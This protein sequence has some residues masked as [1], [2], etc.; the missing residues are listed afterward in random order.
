MGTRS[1]EARAKLVALINFDELLAYATARGIKRDDLPGCAPSFERRLALAG[2]YNFRDA[3][4]YRVGDGRLMRK[5][6]IFRSDHLATLTDDDVARVAS[7][8][9]RCVYDFRLASERERQPSRLPTGPDAPEVVL[10]GTA[11]FSSLD[12]SV[13]DVI[14]DI[15]AGTRPLP[16]PDFWDGNYLDMVQTSQRMLVG[17]LRSTAR[18]EALPALHHC[19]GGKDR[20]GVA[21][22][23]LHRI[24]GV[25]DDDIMNDFLLTNLYRTPY[26]VDDLREGFAARGVSV[27]DALPILGVSRRPLEGVLAHWDAGGGARAYALDGGATE[28][29]LN[30]ISDALLTRHV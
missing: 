14:R 13:I 28:W 18:P 25:G 7:L 29:E 21:T 27:I 19:T 5:G 12:E 22:A 24:L 4:G 6:V 9:L 15:L 23:L 2:N 16:E 17:Y 1:G 10:L 11:D 20:T 30:R 8:R 26:R 3:G